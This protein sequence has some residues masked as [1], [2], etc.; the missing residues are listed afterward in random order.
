VKGVQR[1]FP[2]GRG[3]FAFFVCLLFVLP[4]LCSEL[5]RRRTVASLHRASHCT[6]ALEDRTVRRIRSSCS[7]R[8]PLSE[9]GTG[10]GESNKI[11]CVSKRRKES[12]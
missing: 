12:N 9:K 11:V 10:K 6:G 3:E 8:Q 2:K 4:L 5:D 7:S 1:I